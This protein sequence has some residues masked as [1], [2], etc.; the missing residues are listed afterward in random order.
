MRRTPYEQWTPLA[1]A[2]RQFA[3]LRQMPFVA[4]MNGDARDGYCALPMSNTEKSRASAAICYLDAATRRRDNLTI[5]PDALATH[6]LFEGRRVVGIKATVG[7]A[8]QEFRGREI[9]LCGGAIQSPTL[10]MRSGIGPAAASRAMGI[11]VTADLPGVGQNLQNH[12]V[13]FIGAH[14][15]PHARQA[16]ML[17]T[18][19]F[20]CFRLSSGLPDCPATDLVINLQSKS[21]WS[22]LGAQIANLGPV[23]WKPF[24][25]GQ[26]T[27]VS[28]EVRQIPAGRIQLC[29]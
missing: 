20:S 9:V 26:V 3:E 25:R 16:A 11:E 4:D 7:G 5:V 13:L 21:S 14:L 29:R 17:R 15:R 2:A 10:L 19:Q 27:L 22:A 8:E 12:P 6:L 28:P 18:L 1:Q 24:S 23:L